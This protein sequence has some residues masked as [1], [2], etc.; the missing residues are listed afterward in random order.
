MDVLPVDYDEPFTADKM[1]A[2]GTARGYGQA[3][4]EVE[5]LLDLAETPGVDPTSALAMV[6]GWAKDGAAKAR[7]RAELAARRRE[8]ADKVLAELQ[9]EREAADKKGKTS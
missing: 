3:S 9:Q 8:V 4:A 7:E 6:R 2:E 5:K 1:L